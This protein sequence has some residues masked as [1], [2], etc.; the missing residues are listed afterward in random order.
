L[1]KVSI[2]TVNFNQGAVTGEFLESFFAVNSYPDTELIVVDNGS[3]T[4]SP[5]TLKEEYPGVIFIRS[6]KNTGFAGG[7]NLGIARAKGD[8]LFFV[9]NDTE[10]TSDLIAKLVHTLDRHPEAGVVSPKIM[11]HDKPDIIQYAGFSPMNFYTG[12]NR[13]I[14]QYEKD[15]GQYDNM[16]GPT[17]YA[18]GAAMMVRREAIEK[19]GTMPEDFFLY[20]EEMDWCER[21]KRAGYQIWL[22]PRAVIYHKESLS[23]GKESP[24]K[25]YYMTRNRILFIRRNAGFLARKLFILHFTFLVT[26]RNT[27]VYL[28]NGKYDLLK[29][30]FKGWSDGIR[31]VRGKNFYK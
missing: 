6:E 14:G 7:N 18:H 26:P 27:A 13:C 12:R 24:L 10:F 28:L 15:S 30:F 4:E 17:G 23:V 25:E 2:I 5:Q 21:I 8:Y 16:P 31:D 11:Y 22:E 19:A 29:A 3:D 20:Y 1:K 9:N